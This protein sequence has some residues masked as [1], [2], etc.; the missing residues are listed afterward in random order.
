[1]DIEGVSAMAQT[2]IPIGASGAIDKDGIHAIQNK[3]IIGDKFG[4][5][6]LLDVSR[7]LLLD[8][9]DLYDKRRI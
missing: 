3:I 7:K 5:L 8:K 1:M 9:I 2:S 6:H 4:S